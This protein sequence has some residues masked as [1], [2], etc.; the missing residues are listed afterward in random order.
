M[1]D[2]DVSGSE[3]SRLS[4]VSEEVGHDSSTSKVSS[5]TGSNHKSVSDSQP[6]M[7]IAVAEAKLVM[8][9]KLLVYAVLTLAAIGS[10]IATYK[11][12]TRG[13]LHDFNKAVSNCFIQC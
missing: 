11:F 3:V 7:E 13:E 5:E 1:T 9:S 12:V 2:C 4:A 6:E 10:G 8:C